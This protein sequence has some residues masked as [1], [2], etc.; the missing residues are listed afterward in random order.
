MSI[1]RELMRRNTDGMVF[2]SEKRFS[3]YFSLSLRFMAQAFFAWKD[4]SG[5]VCS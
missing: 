2:H 4:N 1:T 3:Y 5:C